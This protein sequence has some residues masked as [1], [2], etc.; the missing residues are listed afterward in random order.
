[1]VAHCFIVHSL[2][3]DNTI[4]F[5]HFFE[6]LYHQQSPQQ[7]HAFAAESSSMGEKDDSDE[8]LSTLNTTT[9]TATT[10]FSNLLSSISQSTTMATT[11]TSGGRKGKPR[12][13]FK[14]R[15]QMIA[16]QVTNDLRERQKF[17]PRGNANL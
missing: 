15:A 8:N 12:H 17:E 2:D 16:T 14:T 4:W 5:S 11:I 1:M 10:T 9:T 7:Q 3:G 13:P 6:N